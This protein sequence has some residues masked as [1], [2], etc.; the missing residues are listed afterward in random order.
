MNLEQIDYYNQF[1]TT[2]GVYIIQHERVDELNDRISDRQFSDRALEPHYDPRP[3]PTKYSRFP[4]VDRRKAMK[5]KEKT[6][7][8]YMIDQNFAPITEKGPFSGYVNNIDHENS[9]RNQYFALQ[10]DSVHNQY[11]PS[12]DS[13]LYNVTIVSKP[14]EQPFKDLFS[15]NIF[16]KTIHPNMSNAPPIGNDIFFNHTRTQL[17]NNM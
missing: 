5:E 17:R 8:E 9:L 4:I 13:D 15:P 7:N 16:D 3:V 1:D 11:I 10:R 12:T 14:T 6:Y 2:K